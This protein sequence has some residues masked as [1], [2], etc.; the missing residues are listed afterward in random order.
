MGTDAHLVIVDAPHPL[1]VHARERLD[2]LEMRWS[3]FVPESEL[4]RLN[5]AAGV[6][7]VVSP[8]TFALVEHACDAW[9]R[10]RGAFDPTVL[11]AVEAAG[12]DRD[13]ASVAPVGEHT[14]QRPVTVPGCGGIGLDPLVRS[15]TLPVGVR[16]DFGG[17]GK[18][19]AADLVA[20]ELLE[21]GAAGVCVNLGGDLRVEGRPPDGDAGDAWVIEIE[22]GGR[23][24]TSTKRAPTMLALGAGAV[25]T[26][27]RERRVWRRGD[28]VLHHV[29]DPCTGAPAITPWV[30]ATVLTGRAVD[31]EPLAKATLLAPTA[32]VAAAL[33][34]ERNA[35]GCL[36]DEHGR[37]H[38][39][40]DIDRFI[41]RDQ[42]Q[43]REVFGDLLGDRWLSLGEAART[44]GIKT[45]I[46]AARHP[47]RRKT[48]SEERR[49]P[50]PERSAPPRSP[51]SWPSEPTSGSSV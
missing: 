19:F 7:V 28:Q 35:S 8:A 16:L 26:S 31:A 49:S 46:G 40:G 10:T 44:V 5:A 51:R 42:A 13:F 38:E 9:S 11:P 30:S 27:S 48:C 18:G 1:A 15:V 34:G 29:I 50:P 25:A 14:Q 6:P 17:I 41:V 47:T 4:C 32:T 33:L 24:D 45:R 23:A 22:V 39:L 21:A 37:V 43:Q 2:E 12:Y 36:V 20:E 3:R